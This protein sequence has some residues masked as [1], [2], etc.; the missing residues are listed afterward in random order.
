MATDP[1]TPDPEATAGPAAAPADDIQDLVLQ[2]AGTQLAA[3]SAFVRFW[4]DWTVS[5]DAYTRGLGDELAR[6]RA[7]DAADTVGR[8][9]DL[10]QAYVRTVIALPTAAARHFV[11][12][13]E[14]GGRSPGGKER[15]GARTRAAR[16][17]V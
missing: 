14:R 9:S 13:V 2:A 1:A 11:E 15:Q 5:A 17:K 10:T 6:I 16:A 3:M 7:G 4:A 8:V 12:E